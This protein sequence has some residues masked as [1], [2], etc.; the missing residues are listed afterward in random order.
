MWTGHYLCSSQWKSN[1]M[2]HDAF[3]VR[4][5]IRVSVGLSRS[6][7]GLQPQDA[8]KTP[9]MLCYHVCAWLCAQVIL[10]CVLSVRLRYGEP[11]TKG[12]LEAPEARL[13]VL[14]NGPRSHVN[15]IHIC[16]CVNDEGCVPVC[17]WGGW[18]VHDIRDKGQRSF[19]GSRRKTTW[20][21]R[22][23]LRH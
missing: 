9:N 11:T 17:M 2:Q 4:V 5:D 14:P 20:R 19:L 13:S 6:L 15:Q 10:P 8:I 16:Q 12:S 7:K 22:L 21:Y 23:S 3:R 18:L 1:D